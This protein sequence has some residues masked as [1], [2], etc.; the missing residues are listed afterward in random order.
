MTDTQ[1]SSAQTDPVGSGT[2]ECGGVWNHT[3]NQISHTDRY[4]F[5]PDTRQSNTGVRF[6]R[7]LD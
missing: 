3:P 4:F 6:V 1:I 2:D 7:S 5:P